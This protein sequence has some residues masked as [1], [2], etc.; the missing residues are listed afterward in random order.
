[1]DKAAQEKVPMTLFA[2][3]MGLILYRKLGFK[4]VGVARVQV[5]GEDGSVNL[6]GMVKKF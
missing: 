3:P 2:S 6:L 4:E 5:P 1:M